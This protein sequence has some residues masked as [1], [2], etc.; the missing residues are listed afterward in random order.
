MSCCL[1]D[2]RLANK[3]LS[4]T[5]LKGRVQPG[6]HH[7]ELRIP[8]HML[9]EKLAGLKEEVRA[10][11]RRNHRLAQRVKSMPYVSVGPDTNA[12]LGKLFQMVAA[13]HQSPED[14]GELQSMCQLWSS[15]HDH[16]KNKQVSP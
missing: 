7:P 1:S 9:S 4:D 8:T 5:Y 6:A 2:C 14:R 13:K 3:Y 11:R 16:L 12:D 10:L 15:Q